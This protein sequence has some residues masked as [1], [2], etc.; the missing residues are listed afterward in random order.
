MSEQLPPS[1]SIFNGIN[2]NSSFYL[3]NSD[4]LTYDQASKSFLKYPT[5]QGTET[6]QN[7]NVKGTLNMTGNKVTNIDSISGNTYLVNTQNRINQKLTY[8]ST[9]GYYA[10]D[11]E[12][13]KLPNP[14]SSGVKSVSTWTLRSSANDTSGW[15]SVCWSPKLGIFVAVSQT[16]GSQTMY[17]SNGINWTSGSGPG[18]GIQLNAVCWSNALNL[19]VGVG[20][21]STSS[22]VVRIA[23]SLDGITW[24]A[25][26]S[27]NNNVFNGVCFSEEL[28]IFIAVSSG[29][30]STNDRFYKSSDGINWSLSA[31]QLTSEFVSVV[32]APS[33]GLFVAVSQSQVSNP[34]ATSLD[35]DNWTFRTVP[36]PY[37]NN[38]S[39]CWSPELGL[40]AITSYNSAGGNQIITSPDGINWTNRAIPVPANQWNNICWSAETGLFVAIS[41]SGVNNR[42]MSSPNGIDWTIRTSPADNNY[43]GICWSSELGIFCSVCQSGTQRVITSS[44]KG[45]PPTSYNVFDSAYNSISENG[46]WAINTSSLTLPNTTTAATYSNVSSTLFVKSSTTQSFNT[47]SYT[48]N[49]P[50]IPSSISIFTLSNFR[51]YGNYK[52]FLY[53][54][55]SGN[56]IVNATGLGANIKPNWTSNQTITTGQIGIIDINYDGTNY[57][58]RI[59]IY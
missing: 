11:K 14:I 31:T 7:T 29:F 56:F 57:Y 41:K 23:S 32:W 43:T 46:A 30:G 52:L 5:A 59:T 25:R 4:S 39:V 36:A 24:T 8:D 1:V 54:I 9:N 12:K 47:F 48:S 45:R 38:S 35:G 40:F 2:Y 18:A 21:N 53:N 58:L 17:S 16:T 44:L 22:S 51:E 37:S 34:I 27:P 55:G 28:G 13:Q 42:I 15:Y 3:S 6:L 50:S 33:L 19:F 26:N 20:T 10:L 49:V